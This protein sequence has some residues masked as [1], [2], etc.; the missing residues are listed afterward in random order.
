M[1]DDTQESDSAAIGQDCGAGVPP[2]RASGG[3]DGSVE[4][5]EPHMDTVLPPVGVPVEIPPGKKDSDSTNIRAGLPSSSGLADPTVTRQMRRI[6]RRGFI[7]AGLGGMA[8]FGGW[9]WLRTRPDS[10]GIPWPLRK[11]LGLNGR[12]W[13]DLMSR[14]RLAKQFPADLARMPRFNGDIGLAEADDLKK[15]TL[16]IFGLASPD[17]AI[18][19]TLDDIKKLPRVD[20]VTKLCCIEGWSE[21]VHWTGARVSD[22]VMRYPVATKDARLPT[23]ATPTRDTAK[24]LAAETP[25]GEY[26]VGLDMKSALHPQTLLCYE[27]NGNPLTPQHGAPLRLAI[28]VKYGI[29]SLKCV[30]SLTFTNNRPKDYWAEEGYDYFAGL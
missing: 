30:G 1:S 4:S 10:D 28:P 2:A 9:E 8:A 16:Q 11:V 26:Y 5:A 23:S 20:V 29:K 7:V 14:G 25:D 3:S 24:Y 15:W 12:L 6:S 27:M 17:N 22:L 18:E 21:V 13:G 19:L